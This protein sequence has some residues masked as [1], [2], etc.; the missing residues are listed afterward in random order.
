MQSR[1]AHPT[2]DHGNFCRLPAAASAA[3][4][5]LLSRAGAS[6]RSSLHDAGHANRKPAREMSQ[7]GG[8][9]ESTPAAG[10]GPRHGGCFAQ[11]G[12]G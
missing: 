1:S 2:N 4:N 10:H 6:T 11:G 12:D 5:V 7:R 3:R 9:L 8:R